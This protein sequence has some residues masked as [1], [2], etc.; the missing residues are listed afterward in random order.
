MSVNWWCENTSTHKLTQDLCCFS[1]KS[2]AEYVC[3]KLDAT[4]DSVSRTGD[5]TMY[6]CETNATLA[7]DLWGRLPAGNSTCSGGKGCL[8]STAKETNTTTTLSTTS[9]SL[10]ATTR[11]AT[12]ANAAAVTT[13]SGGGSDSAGFVTMDMM[14]QNALLGLVLLSW[15]IK[16]LW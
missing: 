3:G 8:R 9:A 5:P 6:N 7:T 11:S 1:E 15:M 2:C 14:G 10:S 13:G 12:T 16:Q 4:F